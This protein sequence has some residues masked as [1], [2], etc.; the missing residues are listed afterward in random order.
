MGIL[1]FARGKRPVP[2]RHAM[3]LLLPF[4]HHR[5]GI[6]ESGALLG[7]QITCQVGSR[8]TPDLPGRANRPGQFFQSAHH[9]KG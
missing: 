9:F 7:V 5:N 8:H 1:C 2:T 6:W 3:L 4:D